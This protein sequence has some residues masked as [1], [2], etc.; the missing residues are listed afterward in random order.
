[1]PRKKWSVRDLEI[2]VSECK[3]YRCVIKKLGLIPAGGNYKIVKQ[4][5]LDNHIETLHFKGK[6]WNRG[7]NGYII[8]RNITEILTKNSSFQSYKLRNK[9]FLLGLKT[10]KCELC[11]WSIMSKDG[12]IPLE[13]DHIN[14]DNRDNRFEN[15]R[16]LCPNCHSLQPTHRGRNRKNNARVVEW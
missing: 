6:S 7:I 11:G 14:G 16:I 13:L 1:M 8:K 10:K 4:T 15:L 5:I 3:S 12:R 9:L 2:A